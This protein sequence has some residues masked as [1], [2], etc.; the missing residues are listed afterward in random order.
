VE[1]T[2]LF[3]VFGN[4]ILH[5]KSPQLFNSVF[6]ELGK[7]AYYTRIRPQSVFDIVDLIRNLPLSG[8]NITA[9]FKVE[10]IPF[11]D[12]LSSE[13]KMIGAVNTVININ[14][15]L[16]GYNTDHVGVLES[17]NQERVSLIE[18]KCLVIGGGGAARAA[19]YGLIKQ[20]AD[21]I[22]CN[23][24][25]SKA[26]RIASDFGCDIMA[27]D[28]FDTNENFNVLVSTLLPDVVPP[29]IKSLKLNYLLD[30]SYKQSVVFQMANRM[31]I[32][33][34]SGERWLLHQAAEAYRLFFDE[35]IPVSLMEKGLHKQLEKSDVKTVGYDINSPFHELDLH[36]DLI[37]SSKGMDNLQVKGIIDEEFGKA[38]SC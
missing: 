14:G 10:L 19:V 29:F 23:R 8:A 15:K 16:W 13:V 20:G 30:A 24:T 6:K 3:A 4:P 36:T 38:F 9:P 28:T 35:V 27:W 26:Q 25:L 7:D 34:I 1:K 5:S 12:E 32:Q 11:L 33:V 18:A 31:G 21:V 37:V 17:L 22:V 2:K